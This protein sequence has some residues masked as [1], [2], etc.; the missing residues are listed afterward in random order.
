MHAYRDYTP[1]VPSKSDG[2]PY[3]LKM[4]G[5]PF[6]GKRT[7]TVAKFCSRRNCDKFTHLHQS[8]RSCDGKWKLKPHNVE[9]VGVVNKYSLRNFAS[10]AG[11]AVTG[12][13]ITEIITQCLLK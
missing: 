5:C 13:V 6:C 3:P 10:V 7:F 2:H 8:C 4:E 12:G 9:V 11:I 1:P